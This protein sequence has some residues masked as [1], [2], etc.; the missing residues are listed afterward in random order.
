MSQ[1]PA[2]P[3]RPD[4]NDLDWPP[5]TAP[6]RLSLWRRLAY[7]S[8]PLGWWSVGLVVLFIAFMAFVMFWGPQP[9]HDRRTFFSD[10]VMAFAFLG[11]S[12]SGIATGVVAAIA[13]LKRERSVIVGLAFLL[14]VFILYVTLAQLGGHAHVDPGATP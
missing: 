9:G 14:G 2:G 13:L 1:G 7:P 5:A 3:V 11:A 12:A 10:P 8:T 6:G 4:S